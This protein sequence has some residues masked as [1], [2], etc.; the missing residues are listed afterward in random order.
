MATSQSI[1]VLVTCTLCFGRCEV[2]DK[3]AEM[4]C[5]PCKLPM[6]SKCMVGLRKGPHADHELAEM[7]VMIKSLYD[8]RQAL[9]DKVLVD[10][11]TRVD[12]VTKML[13]DLVNTKNVCTEKAKVR[14]TNVHT[15]VDKWLKNTKEQIQSFFTDNER[16]FKQQQE[17]IISN[18]KVIQQSL[19][20][21]EDKLNSGD[22]NT[23][24]S[25]LDIEKK[26]NSSS[27]LQ[28]PG[29]KLGSLTDMHQI[30]LGT[31]KKQTGDIQL[32]KRK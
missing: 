7:D 23:A 26:K 20:I 32:Y 17:E 31:F 21:I 3:E 10:E 27:K 13:E 28:L 18:A 16:H 2:H 4:I 25:L 30:D 14:A 9:S 15:E 12:S 24:S 5:V 22:V 8:E 11:K 1:N 6:C 19:A 29:C